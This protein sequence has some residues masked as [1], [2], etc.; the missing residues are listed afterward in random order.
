MKERS[1]QST[2]PTYMKPIEQPTKIDIPE[3]VVL[4]LPLYVRAL[5]QVLEQNQN[6]DVLSSEQLGQILQISP[7]Q[8]RKDLSYFGKF[9]KQGTGYDVRI[10]KHRL[11][12]IL[13]LDT[14]W[15]ACLVGV[16][17]LGGAIMNYPQF[18]RDGFEIIAAFDSQIPHSTADFRNLAIQPM[19]ELSETV[20]KG[21]ISIGIV[22][23]PSDQVQKVVDKLIIAGIRGILNYAPATPSIP[24]YVVMRNLDP[25]IPLQSMTFYLKNTRL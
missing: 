18:W 12:Q 14:T 8:I 15:K 11:R 22:A 2:N 16:G 23:V 4:R 6:M 7:A 5:T 3:T 13:G 9:G 1:I 21:N 19:S 24:N 20:A 25:I 17:R 10:L